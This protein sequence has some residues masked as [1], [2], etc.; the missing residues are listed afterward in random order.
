MTIYSKTSHSILNFSCLLTIILGFNISH[1]D[2]NEK[3]ENEQNRFYF[4]VE[5]G[6]SIQNIEL[7]SHISDVKELS[8]HISDVKNMSFQRE[9]LSQK[10]SINPYYN[11]AFGFYLP[12]RSHIRTEILFGYK[13]NSI[14]FNYGD[15]FQGNNIKITN[16]YAM[17]NIFY[18][19]SNLCFLT[20]HPFVFGGLGVYKSTAKLQTNS[21]NSILS[22]DAVVVK[23][24]ASIGQR[25]KI[26]GVISGINGSPIKVINVPEITLIN[27]NS[28]DK[29]EESQSKTLETAEDYY[30]IYKLGFGLSFPIY[31]KIDL[32]LSYGIS[33]FGNIQI[34]NSNA[35]MIRNNKNQDMLGFSSI[36][37]KNNKICQEIGFGFRISF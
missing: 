26:G 20:G 2:A 30:P 8:S 3:I 33:N 25:P 4:R 6:G 22:G 24:N 14:K 17:A 5:S 28:R 19:F 36:E 32:D 34:N 27:K 31:K 7:S 35:F 11:G 16:S 18:T 10:R 15:I 13:E 9:A 12:H 1:A 37:F 23:K 29:A 21:D